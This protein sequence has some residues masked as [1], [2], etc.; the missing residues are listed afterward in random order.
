MVGNMLSQSWY[1]LYNNT[2]N[3]IINDGNYKISVDDT[4]SIILDV[5][6]T[7]V[8]QVTGDLQV[9]GSQTTVNSSTL[10]IEDNEIHTIIGEKE[11]LKQRFCQ[12]LSHY[13]D[14][15]EDIEVMMNQY[16]K[17]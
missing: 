12:D 16:L 15:N 3:I 9:D 2:K 5:G 7:G 11:A 4:N 14:K 10:E 13:L 17:L 8:V 1:K 6:A